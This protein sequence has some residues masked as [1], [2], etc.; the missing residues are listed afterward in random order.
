MGRVKLKTIRTR[1]L[2]NIKGWNEFI[3]KTLTQRKITLTRLFSKRFMKE[4][5]KLAR[6]LLVARVQDRATGIGAGDPPSPKPLAP[7]KEATI[8]AKLRANN[9][10][11]KTTP[12]G[13][14]GRS[15]LTHTGKMIDSIRVTVKDGFFRLGFNTKRSKVLAEF[16]AEG[17]SNRK[18]RPFFDLTKGELR[19]MRAL[20]RTRMLSIANKTF[21]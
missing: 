17:S 14:L 21:K 18:A 19:T 3:Q 4:L 15:N 11:G 8:R 9:L 10:S 12:F 13:I 5:G 6:S 16:A 2:K 20:V 7:L 1:K